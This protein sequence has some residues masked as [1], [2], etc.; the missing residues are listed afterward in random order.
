MSHIFVTAFGVV[1]CCALLST[2][3]FLS[4]LFLCMAQGDILTLSLVHIKFFCENTPIW[5]RSVFVLHGDRLYRFFVVVLIASVAIMDIWYFYLS[6]LK[7]ETEDHLNLKYKGIPYHWWRSNG[8]VC[9]THRVFDEERR[10][11]LVWSSTSL[12]E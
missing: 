2:C 8:S 1:A 5:A 3:S 10:E 11:I 6:D 4:H 9:Q 12:H 7:L